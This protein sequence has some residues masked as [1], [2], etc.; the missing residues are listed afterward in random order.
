MEVPVVEQENNDKECRFHFS[1]L[2]M[3]RQRYTINAIERLRRQMLNV[4]STGLNVTFENKGSGT[5]F[6]GKKA[7]GNKRAT[8]TV[9]KRLRK[10]IGAAFESNEAEHLV[11]YAGG[12]VK[13]VKK[14]FART[15]KRAGIKDFTI[16]DLRYT[17]AIWMADNGTAME[18]ILTF[19]G[20]TQ[21]D[22][23]RPDFKQIVR[24]EQNQS[25]PHKGRIEL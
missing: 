12:P 22:I 23:T 13:D 20:H 21:I 9:T 19:L 16:H 11:E 14:S 1:S 17:A 15:V 8:V 24:N 2:D 10:E 4:D 5:L 7:N 3:R 6:L 25:E 18:K